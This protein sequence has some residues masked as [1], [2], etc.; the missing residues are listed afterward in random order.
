MKRFPKEW[1][2]T[3]FEY[4]VDLLNRRIFLLSEMNEDS[5]SYTI[6]GL[7]LMEAENSEALI[8]FFIGS[9]G[10]SEYEMYALYDVMNSIKCPISTCAL[11]KC[12]SAAP[13]LVA[14]G[15]LGERYATPNTWFMVHQSWD[16]EMGGRVDEV[17][18]LIRHYCEMEKQWYDLMSKHTKKSVIFWKKMC[19]NIG[20]S[21]FNVEKAIEYG[22]IDHIWTEK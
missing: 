9:C 22:I 13:L 12:L 16:E 17:N 4:G 6:K 3:Y 1:I 11:G 2:E 20:D 19:K 10:G 18:K 15:K 8:E 14:S 7:Y 21:Y 5:I